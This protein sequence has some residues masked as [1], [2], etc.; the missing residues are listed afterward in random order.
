MGLTPA[1]LPVPR[2]LVQI[3]A[4]A[5]RFCP[6]A[7]GVL[8]LRLRRELQFKPRTPCVQTLEEFLTS[9]PAHALDRTIRPF[10]FAGIFPHHGF[11]EG[12][13]ARRVKHP[14]TR[15]DGLLVPWSFI[16]ISPL[17]I[18]GR[19]HPELAWRNPAE[20]LRGITNTQRCPGTI[21]VP[22]PLMAQAGGAPPSQ[23]SSSLSILIRPFR[24]RIRPMRLPGC[25]LSAVS[26]PWLPPRW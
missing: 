19:P 24:V 16:G 11:P 26:T 14:E 23:N 10:E 22:S 4:I 13:R 21:L 1:V 18:L 7:A 25:C 17:F 5:R 15:R 12:L 3:L 20:A 9:I 2:D 6:R 8:P